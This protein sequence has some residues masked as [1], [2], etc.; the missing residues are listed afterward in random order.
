MQISSNYTDI[1]PEGKNETF[2]TGLTQSFYMASL[3]IINGV[4]RRWR[5]H[6]KRQKSN[7]FSYCAFLDPLAERNRASI[8]KAYIVFYC[9][10]LKV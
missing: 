1:I 9:E 8:G 6:C 5:M 7:N 10:V 2:D 4:H 3:G